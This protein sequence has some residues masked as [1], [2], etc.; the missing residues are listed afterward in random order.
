MKKK[1]YLL[2]AGI[3]SIH[4][5][6]LVVLKFTAWPEMLLWPYLM[7]IGWLPY[8][9]IAI[10]HTPFLITILSLFYRIF[11]VGIIQL[12]IF[13]WI[14]IVGSDLLVFWIIKKLWNQKIAFLS[15]VAYTLLLVFYDGNGLWFDL[16]M[17][18]F[19]FI[20]FY[21]VEKKKYFLTGIFWALASISKQ[22]AVW[23]LLPI[24]Y[25][26]IRD[27]NILRRPLKGDP[28]KVVGKFALG[29]LVILVIFILLLLLFGILPSFYDWAF[30]FGIFILPKAQGQIQLPDLNNL[31][32]SL[33]P[34]LIYI[35]LVW[36]TGKKNINLIFWTVAG[37]MGAYPRFE[38]FHFQPA[39]PFLA[40]AT[41]LVFTNLKMKNIF[42]KISIPVYIFGSIVLFSG[43]FLRNW[44]EGTRFYEQDV[45]D[46]VL[47]VRANTTSNDKIFV[48]NWWDNIYSLTGTMPAVDPWVPQL[49]WYQE[50]P[51]IQEKEVIGLKNSK[52][53]LILFQDYSDSGL[54]SYVPTQVY[55]YVI[56]N[57]KLKEKIDGIKILIPR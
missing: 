29:V 34:F 22:T 4:L 46:L 35:P 30:K 16:F 20:S 19:A 44:K 14:L 43:F 32:I 53:K 49:S 52:P 28:C 45:Q 27:L 54:A 6:L 10:A 40:I 21:F 55:N 18:V 11:G 15:L 48:M 5:L 23:F 9:D 7:K 26:I 25:S 50:L 41:G 56:Q 36:N 47:Y 12:K 2:L 13:T 1:Y 33:F 8:R 42:L 3:I 31:I 57:Y 24:G 51:G 38:Y 37:A 17:G 39:V